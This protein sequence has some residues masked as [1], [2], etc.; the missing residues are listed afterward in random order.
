MPN[1]AAINYHFGDKQGLYSETLRVLGARIARQ[2]IRPTLAFDASASPQKKNCSRMCDRSSGGFSM[3]AG[4]SWYGKLT[5]RGDD[6]A[7]ACA[8]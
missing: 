7:D 2:S 4:P 6:R 1:V 3:K 5:A 8:G